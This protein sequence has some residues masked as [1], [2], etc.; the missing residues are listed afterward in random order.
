MT[1]PVIVDQILKLIFEDTGFRINQYLNKWVSHVRGMGP[2][3]MKDV[4][5]PIHLNRQHR[6]CCSAQIFPLVLRF[7]LNEQQKLKAVRMS[8]T[9][10]TVKGGLLAVQFIGEGLCL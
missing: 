8:G 6:C 7:Q 9:D 3:I 1:T 10:I 5:L 4:S 2:S